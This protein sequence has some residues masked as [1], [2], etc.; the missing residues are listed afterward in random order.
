MDLITRD[1][2]FIANKIS[3]I[4]DSDENY[5]ENEEWIAMRRLQDQLYIAKARADI[6]AIE[7]QLP[8]SKCKKELKAKKAKLQAYIDR[9]CECLKEKE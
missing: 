8:K 1:M 9:T 5:L 4:E 2:L 7:R 3:Q 6:L